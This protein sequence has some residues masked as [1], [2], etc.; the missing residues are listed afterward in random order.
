MLGTLVFRL[1]NNATE[2][3]RALAQHNRIDLPFVFIHII[4]EV[5]SCIFK[6]R[7]NTTVLRDH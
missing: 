7:Y 4:Y 6:C 2:V 1:I 3:Q 5:L